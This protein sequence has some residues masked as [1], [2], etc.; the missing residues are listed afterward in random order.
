[1]PEE[2]DTRRKVLRAATSQR[3]FGPR[4]FSLKLHRGRRSHDGRRFPS[5]RSSR[6]R[7]SRVSGPLSEPVDRGVRDPRDASRV[8][9]RNNDGGW[10]LSRLPFR[11]INAEPERRAG[12]VKLTNSAG[13]SSSAAARRREEL[14]RDSLLSLGVVAE[15][16]PLE[17]RK[18]VGEAVERKGSETGGGDAREGKCS[19]DGRDVLPARI[20]PEERNG[21]PLSGFG[22][23][24]QQIP[25]ENRGFSSIVPRIPA[26]Q[27]AK[28]SME[29][30]EEGNDG[31]TAGSARNDP[32]RSDPFGNRRSV[33]QPPSLLSN[34]PAF[35]IGALRT[36]G[37][38]VQV[39]RQIMDIVESN[40]VLACTKEYLWIKITRWIDT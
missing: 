25:Y 7:N 8:P 22:R 38:F 19:W 18:S 6:E 17:S 29:D 39:G 2:E 33:L 12:V 31:S 21:V 23:L 30:Y 40:V 35:I 9:S 13:N 16:S 10:P 36:L 3:A 28:R 27:R 24:R 15:R 20:P 5:R 11:R 26:G 1:M 32:L 14:S 34:V 4:S 37:M